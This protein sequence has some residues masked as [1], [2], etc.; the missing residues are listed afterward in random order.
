MTSRV[1]LAGEGPNELGG[2]F[3][4]SPWRQPAVRSPVEIG[5]LEALL[6]LT[7]PEGWEIV[8]AVPWKNIRKFRAGGHKH[9]ETR[10][11]LALILAAKEK[12]CDVVVFTRDRDKEQAREQAIH[13]G[14]LRAEKE[15]QDT[16]R[17]A[18]GVAIEETES[19]IL[20]LAGRA[21]SQQMGEE[22]RK[23][24]LAELGVGEKSTTDMVRII[25]QADLGR[26]P[27]DAESLQTWLER[28]RKVLSTASA[29]KP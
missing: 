16:P 27:A 4:E 13:E 6:R 17:V 5:V 11:V 28:V 21:R 24:A 8:D 29:E 12:G 9:A 26:I 18:G 22:Q 7:Q 10:N 19:W 3:K 15:I 23:R 25:E 1:F 20:A 14:I 2:W